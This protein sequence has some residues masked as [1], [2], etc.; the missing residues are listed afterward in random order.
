M[1]ASTSACSNVGLTIVQHVCF[2]MFWNLIPAYVFTLSSSKSVVAVLPYPVS[3]AQLS[4]FQEFGLLCCEGLYICWAPNGYWSFLC[5]FVE[6]AHSDMAPLRLATDCSG[7]GT[8]YLALQRLG[9][10]CVHLWASDT[11][12]YAR[13]MLRL[14]CRPENVYR[15]IYSRRTADLT[16][17]DLYC[18]G[19]PCQPFSTAGLRGG[20]GDEDNGGSI[21][22]GL[23]LISRKK[24][25]ALFC[26]RTLTAFRMLTKVLV[27]SKF[28]VV[29]LISVCIIFIGTLSTQR[30][31]N[32]Q[33]SPWSIIWRLQPVN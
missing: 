20:F 23:L 1:L 5:F 31:A 16:Q 11:N 27:C 24:V 30:S 25:H 21:F 19:F 10:D 3:W 9:V 17:A 29:C 32:G 28:C 12:K 22:S 4:S 15:D 26:W 7:L 33:A 18:V 2:I 13:I 6:L 8:P 14:N